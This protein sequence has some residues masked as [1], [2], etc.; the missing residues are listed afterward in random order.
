MAISMVVFIILL[1]LKHL[2][3]ELKSRV[4]PVHK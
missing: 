2:F 1:F 3:V 4:V